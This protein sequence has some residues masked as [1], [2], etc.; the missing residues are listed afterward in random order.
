[1]E[2]AHIVLLQLSYLTFLGSVAEKIEIAPGE[3]KKWSIILSR[4]RRDLNTPSKNT[5]QLTDATSGSFF[6]KPEDTK[7]VLKP[8]S[9]NDAHI[10][11]K[12]YRHSPNFHHFQ[13]VRVGCRFGT[14][15]VQNLAHQI[16]QYTD[17]D[18]DGTAPVSKISP[19]GYGRRRR[20]VPD[21]KLLLP[22][23]DGKIK[24]WWVSSKVRMSDD[25]NQLLDIITTSRLSQVKTK[26]KLWESLLRT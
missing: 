7:D 15:T 9:S 20:S 22:V 4:A 11:V 6:V 2:L 10:R 5:A 23:V 19:Q 8:H 1:M 14:C 25:Q 12:R 26:G 24:P 18:K 13:S 3:R 21:K 16:F 17:K